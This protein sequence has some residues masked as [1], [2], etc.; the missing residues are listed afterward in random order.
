M[1]L[2]GQLFSKKNNSRLANQ[3]G[4]LLMAEGECLLLAQLG[5]G[6]HFSGFLTGGGVHIEVHEE[7]LGVTQLLTVTAFPYICGESVRKFVGGL[8]GH[9]LAA[10]GGIEGCLSGR[11]VR[12]GRASTAF[13]LFESEVFDGHA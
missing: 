7:D 6:Q 3:S 11:L 5:P 8:P 12:P 2:L 1:P 13:I 9:N 4:A 10:K